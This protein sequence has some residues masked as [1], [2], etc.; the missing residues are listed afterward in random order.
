[1]SWTENSIHF[2]LKLLE[3]WL[4]TSAFWSFYLFIPPY[5]RNIIWFT[6]LNETTRVT[7]VYNERQNIGLTTSIQLL[8]NKWKKNIKLPSGR[9]FA[10]RHFAKRHAWHWFR[11][12]TSTMHLPPS[13]HV[14]SRFLLENRVE[15]TNRTRYVKRNSMLTI[16]TWR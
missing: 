8:A 14:Y 10:W 11:R 2:V 4:K 7:H 6:Q 16:E 5:R 9:M 12:D 1:M 15:I 13:L 3:L